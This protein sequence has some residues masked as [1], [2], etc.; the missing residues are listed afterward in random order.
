MEY[1]K[2]GHLFHEN[3]FLTK[4]QQRVP[5]LAP[6]YIFWGFFENFV[7]SFSWKYSKIKELILL[8]IFHYQIHTWKKSGGRGTGQNA[9]SQSS[10][11]HEGWCWFLPADKHE[12]FL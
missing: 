5:K 11:K 12:S 7:V 1:L 8:L 3:S 4:C 10:E 6:K 9:D 2:T